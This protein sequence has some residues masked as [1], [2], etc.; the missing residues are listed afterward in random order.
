MKRIEKAVM[1]CSVKQPKDIII[2]GV[3]VRDTLYPHVTEYALPPVDEADFIAAVAKAIVSQGKVKGGSTEDTAQRDDDVK[4]LFTLM[5]PTLIN[6]VNGLYVGQKAKLLLSGFDVSNDPSPRNVPSIPVI[7]T[8]L[9]SGLANTAKVVLE[10]FDPQ[11][12]GTRG[13]VNITIQTSETEVDTDFRTVLTT[14]NSKKLLIPGLARGKETHIRIN[15]TNARGT[16]AWSAVY[17]F[18]P[19]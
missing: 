7:K 19:Q 13:V 8:V 16:S 5:N 6:Y 2:V 9:M 12:D 3:K 15:A 17:H 1:H 18:I 11:P 10:P 4:D 14:T